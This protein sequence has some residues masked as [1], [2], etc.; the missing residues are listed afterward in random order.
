[1]SNVHGVMRFT[2]RDNMTYV[3]FFYNGDIKEYNCAIP[4]MRYTIQIILN[5]VQLDR[6]SRAYVKIPLKSNIVT[7]MIG[8]QTQ[9][10]NTPLS[11]NYKHLYPNNIYIHQP[12]IKEYS[13]HNN[14]K[15]MTGYIVSKDIQTMKQDNITKIEYI[16]KCI[17][18]LV[19]SL[20]IMNKSLSDHKNY[21]DTSCNNDSVRFAQ[22][23]HFIENNDN[24]FLL[25]ELESYINNINVLHPVN[26]VPSDLKSIITVTEGQ[27][28]TINSIPLFELQRRSNENIEWATIS[29]PYSY[30]DYTMHYS[31]LINYNDDISSLLFV[32][33]VRKIE[34]CSM[35]WHHLHSPVSPYDNESIHNE[36]RISEKASEDAYEDGGK[37]FIY[38][39]FMVYCK[40][41][42]ESHMDELYRVKVIKETLDSYT[43][44][45]TKEVIEGKIQYYKFDP[46]TEYFVINE[47]NMN[48]QFS[49]S[50][51]NYTIHHGT[52]YE[53]SE[54]KDDHLELIN[55]FIE[56]GKGYC[57]P[58]TICI[59]LNKRFK[60]RQNVKSY[61]MTK[62]MNEWITKRR[63]IPQ[64]DNILISSVDGKRKSLQFIQDIHAI[65]TSIKQWYAQGFI[66]FC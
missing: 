48:I 50:K 19:C 4:Y 5:D 20:D 55:D 6:N 34:P 14:N 37:I 32:P 18:N 31:P 41:K 15:C 64:N 47:K 63:F 2:C 36:V 42:K 59:C 40:S 58:K 30:S 38:S 10:I 60:V 13:F 27:E 22:K 29:L 24:H 12:Y 65:S 17:H 43:F 49:F 3:S 33:G 11:K 66:H 61:Q 45:F 52:F 51:F 56:K 54:C 39:S 57:M 9:Y 35:C 23:M 8:V 46:K 16:Q 26:F 1:M 7:D 21:V 44:N 28:C 62:Q 25:S 53:F